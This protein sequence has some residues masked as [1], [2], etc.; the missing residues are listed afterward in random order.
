[1]N[2]IDVLVIFCQTLE[3]KHC[4]WEKVEHILVTASWWR[5]W[6]NGSTRSDVMFTVF[7]FLSSGSARR[8]RKW[9]QGKNGEFCLIC[10]HSKLK[11]HNKS[12]WSVTDINSSLL[13]WYRSLYLYLKE[14]LNNITL[15]LCFIIYNT[16]LWYIKSRC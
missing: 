14:K 7:N 16:D 9:R 6:D 4:T 3:S 12:I 15:Y 1:M 8:S 13:V 11:S 2:H 5:L 10:L